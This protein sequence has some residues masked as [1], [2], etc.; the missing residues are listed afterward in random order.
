MKPGKQVQIENLFLSITGPFRDTEKHYEL[1]YYNYCIIDMN[2]S[3]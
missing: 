1:K 3:E 2:C